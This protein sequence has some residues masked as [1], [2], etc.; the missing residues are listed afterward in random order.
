MPPPTAFTVYKGASS[1]DLW[2]NRPRPST[3]LRVQ[4]ASEVTRDTGPETMAL[5]PVA[6]KAGFILGP[7]GGKEL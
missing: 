7:F 2:P 5:Q 6:W 3:L 1:W 4:R